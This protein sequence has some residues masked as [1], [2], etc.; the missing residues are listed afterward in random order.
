MIINH[1]YPYTILQKTTVARC[2]KQLTIVQTQHALNSHLHIQSTETVSQSVSHTVIT[3]S[4]TRRQLFSHSCFFPSAS[5]SG[6]LYQLWRVGG[7]KAHALHAIACNCA[8][9]HALYH[10]L[11]CYKLWDCMPS[12]CCLTLAACKVCTSVN[13]RVMTMQLLGWSD[14]LKF[15]QWVMQH[16]VFRRP[17]I[18]FGKFRLS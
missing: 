10:A 16:F 3:Y 11:A 15:S 1:S 7:A 5:I 13:H 9:L 18:L 12:C 8:Q 17:K 6:R 14:Q 4:H 2:I